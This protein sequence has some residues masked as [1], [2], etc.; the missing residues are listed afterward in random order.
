MHNT[1]ILLKK[2]FH[3]TSYLSLNGWDKVK[4]LFL[5]LPQMPI[6]LTTY[7]RSEDI[8]ELP[9]TD[10]FHS[11]ELFKVYESTQGYRPVLITA[12]LEG[13]I[14]GKLLGVVRRSVRLSPPAL[15]KRC[16]VYGCGEYFG[17]YDDTQSIFEAMLNRLTSE[18]MRDAFLIEFRNINTSLFGYGVFRRAHYF[19]VNWLRVRNPLH[20]KKTV[21]E[22]F[23]T[24]R[25]RQIRKGLRNG[26]TVRAACTVEEVRGFARMLHRVYSF[27]VRRHFP[28]KEFFRN[29]ERQL[30][31]GPMG[32]IFIV[33]YRGHIIG[34]SA[35]IYSD[36]C[37]YLW[38]SGGMRKTYPS[39]YP[40]VLA[41]WQ[42]LRDAK[43]RGYRYLEF[44]DVGMPFFRHGYREFVLRFG[45]DQLSTRRW[46]RLRWTWLNKILEYLY[47]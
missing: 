21:E 38:F 46:F 39:Q 17:Q 25:L 10:T 24:S 15:I 31:D 13:E 7:Y 16:E 26:A 33:L 11:T 22:H 8:P 40:G 32:R 23:S 6:K 30:A 37:A 5:Y 19:A 1:H 2:T 28:C 42:A 34:G 44:M 3:V 14:A 47:R 29:M 12:S 41:V 20:S 4:N 18:A 43:E 35:C 9:G 27:N 36:D 45:G